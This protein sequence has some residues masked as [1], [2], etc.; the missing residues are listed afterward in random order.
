MDLP[1][2]TPDP[3]AFLAGGG[4]LGELI[5]TFDWRATSLGP[6]EEWPAELLTAVRI[7][8][9][10]TQP[11]WIGW[12]DD[13]T[14][15]YNDP[16]K[17]IIGGKAPADAGAA[18][19][20]RVGRDLGHDRADAGAGPERGQGHV[21][22]VAAA[23][24]GAERLPGGDLLHLLVRPDP[25][26]LGTAAGILCANTDDT[27]RAIGARQLARLRELA[28]RTISATSWREARAR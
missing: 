28:P 13:L 12:G 22:G 10:S 21:R 2:N 19:E 1:A 5:R 24:H 15:L 11:I 16:Y 8:L 20:G 9:T 27:Q 25:R 17:A 4:E 14:Y 18:D 6:P 23:H 7:M 26:R 3:L